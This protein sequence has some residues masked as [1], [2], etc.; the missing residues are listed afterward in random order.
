MRNLAVALA[1]TAAA[2]LLATGCPKPDPLADCRSACKKVT[3]CNLSHLA[4]ALDCANDC[5]ALKTFSECPSCLAGSS[6]TCE[7]IST[8]RSCGASCRVRPGS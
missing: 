3:D 2:G 6:T 4:E 5:R 7:S 8:A 1:L